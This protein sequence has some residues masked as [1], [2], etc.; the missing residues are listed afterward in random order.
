MKIAYPIPAETTSVFVVAADRRSVDL[1]AVVPW[2][3]GG[4]H[5]K[6]AARA[7]G[8]P[9]LNLRVFPAALSPWRRTS[10]GDEGRAALHAARHHVVVTA[11]APVAEQ[12]EAAQVARAVARGVAD[13]CRGVIVDVIT[14]GVV[15]HRTGCQAE[16]GEFHLE[17]DW[18]GWSTDVGSGGS[19]P[20]CDPAGSGACTCLTV[21]TRGLRRF[22]LPEIM[23]EGAA[24]V[25]GLCTVSVLRT[26]ARC[27][28][29]GHLT[30]SAA[31]PETRRRSIGEHLWIGGAESVSASGAPGL[32]RRP[33]RVRLGSRADGSCLSVGP[34]SGFTGTLN[35]WLCRTPGLLAA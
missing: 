29:P 24:C 25:H 6:A 13:T 3:T 35:D 5:R 19:C 11:T 18:L 20:P 30:W 26:V 14:G 8:T 15:P 22:G 23:L 1:D 28:L 32:G 7:I 9:Q 16:P 34:P 31:S 4:P 21:A 2:R 27:L 10:L 12:P 33:F 17:D